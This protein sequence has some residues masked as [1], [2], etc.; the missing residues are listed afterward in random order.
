VGTRCAHCNGFMIPSA[1]KDEPD[2]CLLCGRTGIAP[3]TPDTA[4]AIRREQIAIERGETQRGT[5]R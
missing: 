2:A 5:M 1:F 4:A 3:V